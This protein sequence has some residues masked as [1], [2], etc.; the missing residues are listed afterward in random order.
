MISASEIPDHLSTVEHLSTGATT[1][2][3]IYIYIFFNDLHLSL[4]DCLYGPVVVVTDH[5]FAGRI[6]CLLNYFSV[7]CLWVHNFSM[8]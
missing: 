3:I 2:L 8:F 4:K 5:I 7:L 6:S 1:Y